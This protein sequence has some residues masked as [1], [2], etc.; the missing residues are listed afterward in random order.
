MGVLYRPSGAQQQIGIAAAVHI[1][2]HPAV[3]WTMHM[4]LLLGTQHQ[5]QEQYCPRIASAAWW[6]EEE[7]DE[8]KG[9]ED[10]DKWEQDEDAA[11]E[12]EIEEREEAVEQCEEPPEM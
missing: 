8:G 6:G 12:E 9:K 4:L 10:K 1:C 11:R 5:G 3:F 7:E 2:W